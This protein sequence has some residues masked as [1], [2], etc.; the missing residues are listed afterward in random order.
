MKKSL[1]IAYGIACCFTVSAQAPVSVP[2]LSLDINN[3][4]A[5]INCDGS[6]FTDYT[7]ARFEAPKG[8]GK[9]TIF[10]S[11]LWFGGIDAGNQLHMS[12]Q[13]YRQHGTDFFPGPLSSTGTTDSATMALAS[14]VWKLNKCDI[15][16]YHQWVLNGSLPPIPVDSATLHTIQ[17]WPAVSA[18]GS[19][20]A[21]YYDYNGDGFYD[22]AAGDYPLIQGDQAIFFVYNDNGGIHGETGGSALGLEVQGMAYGFSCND[23]A[24]SNTVFVDYTV[25][26]RSATTYTNF[27]AGSWTDFDIGSYNDDY[28]GSDATRGAYYSYNGAATDPAYGATPPAQGVVFLSSV[29]KNANL[30][31]DPADSTLNGSG[32]NDGIVDNEQLGMNHFIAYGNNLSVTGNPATAQE[33][34]N[35]FSSTWK[36][37]TPLT[38]GGTGYTTSAG[39]IDDFMFPGDSDPTGYGSHCGMTMAPWSEVTAS[40]AP[41]DRRGIASSGPATLQPGAVEYIRLAYV[42]AKANSGDN[43]ASLP[44]MT[45]RIDS[46]KAR[47]QRN[48]LVACGCTTSTGITTYDA[49]DALSVF[50]NPASD[51]LYI[52]Y[53]GHAAKA[54]IR[55]YDMKGT[56]VKQQQLSGTSVTLDLSGFDNGLYLLSLSDGKTVITK[57]FLK[58]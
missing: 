25:I 43:L 40:S 10:A 22:P 35:Y 54:L 44:L 18:S 24:L 32:Y 55:V 11:Q 58:N 3:I 56:L 39:C 12:A 6:L 52:S 53:S 41:G 45:E 29:Y 50:P 23:S 49:P 16:A 30:T 42:F 7:N 19:P 2:G 37:G 31:D 33:Y 38:D 21:P 15:D 5:R 51:Q 27:Y 46:V 8:S 47:Y 48:A 14:R 28:I 57:K 13:T 1:L 17:E 9:N 34:Y 4:K 36:D 26:N 20:L